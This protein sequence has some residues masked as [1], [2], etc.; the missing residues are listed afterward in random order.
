MR[1]I[2][3][4]APALATVLVAGCATSTAGFHMERTV[5]FAV[6]HTYLWGPPDALP[7]GDPR[8]DNN[9]MFRDELQ[10]TAEKQFAI[11]GYQLVHERPDLLVHYHASVNQRIDVDK[12]DRAYGYC[13]TSACEP[14]V[15]EYE[16]GTIIIDVVDARTNRVIWRGWS[17]DSMTG[18][19]D[20]QDRLKKQ[21]EEGVAK[22]LAS[23]PRA[24]ITKP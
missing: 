24:G 20:H 4:L 7:V 12:T 19:I 22:L 6:Y 8:L 1:R 21:V 14:Q 15:V 13:A 11:K 3:V 18:I 17:Q 5:D 9:S 23:L 16:Q 10:G 2:L